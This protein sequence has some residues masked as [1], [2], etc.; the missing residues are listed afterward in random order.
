MTLHLLGIGEGDE[1]IVPAY[2]YTASASVVTHVGAKLVIVDSQ[3]N[4]TEM[5]YD[6]LVQYLLNK[7]GGSKYDYF[8]AT[9]RLQ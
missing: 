1:V 2:T 9:S 3:T 6:Q 5:D 4:S 8:V 7:Y